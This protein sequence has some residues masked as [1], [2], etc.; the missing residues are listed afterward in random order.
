M[1]RDVAARTSN[2]THCVSNYSQ[3]ASSSINLFTIE[4]KR[5]KKK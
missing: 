5:K 1:K 2:Y 4:K 3:L